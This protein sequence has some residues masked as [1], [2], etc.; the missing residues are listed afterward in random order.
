MRILVS[1]KS[2]N[3]THFDKYI[4]TQTSCW[5]AQIQIGEAC[6][7]A[8]QLR[9][10]LNLE[11]LWRGIFAKI[12]IYKRKDWYCKGCRG[13]SYLFLSF[14]L[15]PL[16][17]LFVSSRPTMVFLFGT[18]SFLLVFP[19]QVLSPHPSSFPFCSP[20]MED[21]SDRLHDHFPAG[22][23]PSFLDVPVCGDNVGIFLKAGHMLLLLLNILRLL[24]VTHTVHR[25]SHTEC[26][27]LYI[28]WWLPLY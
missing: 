11:Y 3:F 20:W 12:K 9:S 2:Y 15:F 18:F 26:L 19:E 7:R 21:H 6:S 28:S 23:K 22:W 13:S 16:S 25:L 1:T 27:S 4:W 14:P 17:S 5:K 8:C 24:R 10:I